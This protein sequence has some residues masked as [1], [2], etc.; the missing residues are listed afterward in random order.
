MVTIK[1]EEF[2]RMDSRAIQTYLNKVYAMFQDRQKGCSDCIPD[3]IDMALH[4]IIAL[5]QW[6]QEVWTQEAHFNV[7]SREDVLAVFDNTNNI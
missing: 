7:M 2:V 5:T 3:G 1:K 4:S 6:D